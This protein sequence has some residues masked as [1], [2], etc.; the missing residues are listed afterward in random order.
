M[1][2]LFTAMRA[3]SPKLPFWRPSQWNWVWKPTF[4]VLFIFPKTRTLLPTCLFPS[5]TT[6]TRGWE[7]GRNYTCWTLSLNL[8]CPR[9]QFLSMTECSYFVVDMNTSQQTFLFLQKFMDV[10][11]ISGFYYFFLDQAEISS[12]QQSKI[13]FDHQFFQKVHKIHFTRNYPL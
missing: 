6:I 3:N 10:L 1:S 4:I 12:S 7:L 5:S 13:L 9:R 8:H 2:P 11:P